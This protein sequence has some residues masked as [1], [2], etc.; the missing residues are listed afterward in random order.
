MILKNCGSYTKPK[1]SPKE[2]PSI[3]CDKQCPLQSLQRLVP[4]APKENA[5]TSDGRIS[6]TT[7]I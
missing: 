2:Y 5:S 4:K 3:N 1:V 7:G 6:R